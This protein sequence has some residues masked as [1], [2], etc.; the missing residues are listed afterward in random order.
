[1]AASIA[2][3]ILSTEAAFIG[4]VVCG[5]SLVDVRFL[6]TVWVGFWN[7]VALKNHRKSVEIPYSSSGGESG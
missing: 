4:P 6:Y 7:W 1:M 2:A 5:R 3:I